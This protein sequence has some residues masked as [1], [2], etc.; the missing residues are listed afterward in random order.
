[1]ITSMFG[2][3]VKNVWHQDALNIITCPS[4]GVII[5]DVNGCRSQSALVHIHVTLNSSCYFSL[6]W[7]SVVLPFIWACKMLCFSKMMVWLNVVSIIRIFPDRGNVQ[8]LFWPTCSPDLSLLEN[9]TQW[10]PSDWLVIIHQ[11]LLLMHFVEAAK[12]TV[13]VHDDVQFL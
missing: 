13:P 5:W 8:L 1:M 4:P 12:A 9:S 6:L 10:M 11:S 3:I 2:K 7:R